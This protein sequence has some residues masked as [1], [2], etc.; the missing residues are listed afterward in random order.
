MSRIIDR[1]RYKRTYP[2]Y[3][4]RPQDDLLGGVVD[5]GT[6][7]MTN[8]LYFD[9]PIYATAMSTSL[10]DYTPAGG[11]ELDPTIINQGTGTKTFQLRD[12]GET[13][14]PTL[15]VRLYNIT[16]ASVV[17]NSEIT[18]S[19]AVPELITSPDLSAY[20]HPGAAI[21]QV[22]MKM[23]SGGTEADVVNLTCA[24]LR[25]QWV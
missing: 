20:L 17:T 9:T 13:T 15:S 16:T 24:S 4:P 2:F 21:Y 6:S 5:D 25:T 12:V 10:D 7:S 19:S 3:K 1:Q 14:G 22:Q 18:T 8:P 23:G 11:F